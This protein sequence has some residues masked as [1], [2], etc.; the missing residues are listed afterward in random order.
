MPLSLKDFEYDLPQELIAQSPPQERG[1]SRLLQ[2]AGGQLADLQFRNLPELT[3][4]GDLMVFNDTRVIKARLNGTKESGGRVEVLV[5]RVCGEREVLAQVRASKSPRAGVKL[6]L[7]DGL[8]ANVT[9]REDDLYCLS[10]AGELPVH[11]LLEQF[12]EVPL[13]PYVTRKPTE[14]DAARYQTVFAREP[15]AV[16]APTAGLHF[17]DGMLALLEARGVRLA[18]VTL[19]VGAGTFQP[20][21]TE[22]L[23]QH[24]MHRER[25]SIPAQTRSAILETKNRGG[26]VIAVGTTSMRAL[27]SA[28]IITPDARLELRTGEAETQLFILPGYHFKVVDRLVTNFHLPRSTLLMLVSAF[29]GMDEIRHAYAHAIAH[30]YRF[31]S[32]GDAMLIDRKTE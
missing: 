7:G 19:H 21:R 14:E 18:W 11:T 32:Y 4:A 28:A 31:F 17:D 8:V 26:R 29:G 25:Y 12:G 10:F 2:L 27:E 30:R 5:E 24:Q 15:G 22:R 20:L 16:A 13:P 9:G 6:L 3:R 1:T 23:E